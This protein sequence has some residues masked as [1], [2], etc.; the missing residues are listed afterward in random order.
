M[1]GFT[2][3]EILIAV[4]LI[5][6][7]GTVALPSFAESIR[8]SRRS[9]AMAA[10]STI[11]QAQE[12]YRGNN[13]SYAASLTALGLGSTSKPRGYYALSSAAV[14][15]S[16]ATAYVVTADGSGGSQANDGTCGKLSVKMDG[17]A[18]TYASCK[19]CTSFTYATTDR[20]WSR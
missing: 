11:Q 17:P 12:R 18:I 20:C 6:I 13:A 7:I 15:G 14:M 1:R 19:D 8:K 9:E 10:I 5:A 2:L 4:A 16:T 3:I